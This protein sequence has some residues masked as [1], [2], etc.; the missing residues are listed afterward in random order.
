MLSNLVKLKYLTIEKPKKIV[1]KK[2]VYDEDGED[3][4]NICKGKLSFPISNILDPEGI[5]PTLTATDSN[6]IVTIIDDKYIRKLSINELKLL[7]GFPES[8]KISSDV[9]YYDLFGNMVVPPIITQI[10]K[11][12]FDN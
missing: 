6:K 7:C 10:L 5:S 9:N 11:C 3:G 1:E 2:R 4:Y 12:I 8:Y